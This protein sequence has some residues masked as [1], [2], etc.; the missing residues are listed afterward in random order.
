MSD[1]IELAERATERDQIVASLQKR[2]LDAGFD[3]YFANSVMGDDR[4]YLGARWVVGD[5]GGRERH[6]FLFL[7]EAVHK[8]IDLMVEAEAKHD[9]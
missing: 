2:A 3:F 6:L 9:A 1:L 5:L 4:K 8:L 7:H